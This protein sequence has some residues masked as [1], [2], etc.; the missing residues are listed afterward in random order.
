[1]GAGRPT[2][3]GGQRK[4]GGSHGIPPASPRD[5]Q[6]SSIPQEIERLVRISALH[7][8][9]DNAVAALESLERAESLAAA[10]SPEPVLIAD[11]K[12][13]ITDCL[14][15]RGDLSAALNRISEALELVRSDDE[16]VLYGKALSREGAIRAG[17]GDYD[18]AFESCEK[19]YDL[20]RTSDE[21]VEIGLL[22]LTLGT[23]H[24]RSGRIRESQEFFESAL[25]TFRRIDHREGVAR[26][27]NNLG[28]LLKNGPRW[29]DGRDYLERALAVSEEAGN[30]ARVGTHCVNLGIL[31]TKLCEWEQAGKVLGRGIAAHKEIG[32]AFALAKALLAAGHLHRRRGQ[33]E[34]AA[35]HYAE[36][37]MLC[38]QNA[39]AREMVLCHEADG[40]LLADA[41]RADEARESLRRGLEL[42]V[43]VAPE[44]DLVPELQRRLASLALADEDFA[45]ARRLAARS[46]R[47]ARKV[48][49]CAE[50]GAALRVLG[51]A[52]SLEGREKPAGRA[53]QQAVDMLGQTPE[54]F[55]L[56]LARTALGRHLGRTKPRKGINEVRR[57]AV[58][59]LQQ[60]WAFFVSVDLP[61]MAAETLADLARMRVSF[62][63]VEGALRD[64]ARGHALAEK[65][66]RED[67]LA[68]LER[69]RESLE[70]RSAEAALLTSPEVEIIRAW[71]QL[72]SEGGAAETWLPS[73]LCFVADRLESSAAILATPRTGKLR[74]VARLGVDAAAA[75]SILKAIEPHVD[76]NGIA[77]ATDLAHDP[78]FAARKDGVFSGVRSLAVLS[79]NLPKGKGVLYLDRRGQRAE[80]Y[81]RGDLRVLSVLSGLLG[82]GLVQ[83]RR[84]RALEREQRRVQRAQR[85]GPFAKYITASPRIQRI[86]T[87]LERVGDSTASILILGETG[88]G[89]GLIAK[90]V[91][92]AS[93]RGDGPFV[94]VNCAAIPESL[95]ESELFGHV[96]GS[97]TGAV[98]DKRGLFD[99]ASGGTLFL[100]EIS[101][102]SLAVQAK[103]LH[104]LDTHEIRAVGATR[105]RAVDVRVICASNVDL[106]EAI[107]SGAFLEDLF[108][109]VNDFTVQL[110]PLRRREADIPLLLNH[111]FTQACQDMAR[112]PKGISREVRTL[113]ADF[114]W[115]GNI[116]ELIQVVRRLVALAEDGEMITADLLPS[117]LRHGHPRS[118]AGVHSAAGAAAVGAAASHGSGNGRGLRDQVH[119]LERELISDALQESGW[120]RSQAA[121]ALSISY[122]NLLA[123]IKLFGLHPPR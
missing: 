98:R 102:T 15:R 19:A 17:L 60:S 86:F 47:G 119:T 58:D 101:R 53:L 37:R 56:A 3:G 57:Q 103:L 18:A 104:V 46:A 51:E 25:V 6:P 74:A 121:R 97:F 48:G 84:E 54:R 99:E 42:A 118:A 49:D 77:L 44:G 9:A 59:L 22:E 111:F 93:S 30:Y 24:I 73:M 26:A 115:R 16:P 7:L 45:E 27:L 23:I 28:L 78:R 62:G 11:L 10:H 67:I 52:L 33:R 107:R 8:A 94:Q 89:K 1:M 72:F 82:L 43:H 66:G 5:S 21:H 83:Y 75:R 91:H 14:R 79:L 90:C 105:S 2:N 34:V 38:E 40:D 12:I 120:N 108:Y 68:R 31:Y 116:R 85:T 39:Y 92:E 76:E 80:P 109:R 110:P 71:T 63:D 29:A 106:R 4:E 87:H 32:N 55:E 81:G 61:E 69:I 41:G 113:L 96:Q 65:T 114:E 70:S 20:L 36:A 64:I 122:P 112:H 100:D 35:A 117:E 95:L 50:A 123:K 13:R 88:T